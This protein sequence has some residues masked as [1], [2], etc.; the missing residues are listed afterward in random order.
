MRK[1]VI[2][3]IAVMLLVV[4]AVPAL[5]Q[6]SSKKGLSLERE[7][8]GLHLALG[9]Q[10]AKNMVAYIREINVDGKYV[11]IRN[12]GKVDGKKAKKVMMD[13]AVIVYV[14]ENESKIIGL[15]D[16]KIDQ[17]AQFSVK[18]TRGE[19]GEYYA[20]LVVQAPEKSV[21]KPVEQPVEN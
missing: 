16:L 4:A 15:A 17:K 19:N 20:L 10:K 21:V 3:F 13:K 1:I 9:K 2:G 5:A 18:K 8:N 14:D 11:L 12:G 6:D 7:N